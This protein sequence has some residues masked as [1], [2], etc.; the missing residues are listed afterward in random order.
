MPIGVMTRPAGR[1]PVDALRSEIAVAGDT[2]LAERV[3]A[4]LNYTI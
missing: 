2:A 1:A 4:N 3:V